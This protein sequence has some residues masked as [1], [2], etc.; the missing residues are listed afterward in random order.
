[1]G[2]VSDLVEDL[3]LFAGVGS[4]QDQAAIAARL[5]AAAEAAVGR[6]GATRDW[7]TNDDAATLARIRTQ[8]DDTAFV[9]A[10]EQGRNMSVDD[11]VALALELWDPS[12]VDDTP[13]QA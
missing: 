9:E 7:A 2:L 10:W 5:F 8:L 4:L 13:T 12:H 3:Y 1:M 11:A 6:L